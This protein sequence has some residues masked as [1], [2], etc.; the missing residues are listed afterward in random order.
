MSTGRLVPL[1]GQCV[2][3]DDNQLSV[4]GPDF[5]GLA[6]YKVD[7]LFLATAEERFVPLAETAHVYVEIVDLSIRADLVVDQVAV[8]ECVHTADPAAVFVVVVVAA[9]HAVDNG[10]ALGRIGKI[11]VPIPHQDTAAR[12]AGGVVEPFEFQAGEDIGVPAVPELFHGRRVQQVEAGGQDDA[13]DLDLHLLGLHG[14]VDGLGFANLDAFHAFGT[15]AAVEATGCFAPGRLFAK[16]GFDFIEIVSPGLDRKLF[17]P[18]TALPRHFRPDGIPVARRFDFRFGFGF[19][20]AHVFAVQIA[21]HG[22]GGLAARGPRLPPPWPGRLRRRPRQ[23]HKAE[24]CA[25]WPDE[26]RWLPRGVQ[27]TSPPPLAQGAYT[28]WP[29]AGMIVS[30]VTMN[31]DPAIG[32]GRRRPAGVRFAELGADA[33]QACGAAVFHDHADRRTKVFD[34][35]ALIQRTAYFVGVRRHFHRRPAGK[36]WLRPRRPAAGPH[37]PRP[38]PRCRRR[39][40]PPAFPDRPVCS[41]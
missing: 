1:A 2:L 11:A 8:F 33:L 37:G 20:G 41:G 28:R 40:L 17:R 34:G 12:G 3:T 16:G 35:H 14:M 31:A 7:A 13:A 27:V 18:L 19:Q 15:D 29:M 23:K 38:R 30:A 5:G 36:Q 9:A 25:W 4:F 10:H 24:W 21:A 22:F 39:P 26:L 6:A 32:S